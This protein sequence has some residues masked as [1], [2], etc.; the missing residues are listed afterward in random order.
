M[1]TTMYIA[2]HKKFHVPN[3]KGYKPIEVGADLRNGHFGYICDNDGE[4]ISKKN[5]TFCELTAFYWIWKNDKSD[6]VG[7]CHYRR[8]FSRRRINTSEKFYLKVDEIEKLLN[9]YDVI[10]PEPFYW[11]KHTVKTGYEFGAGF[12]RD[13]DVIEKIIEMQS[14][15]FVYE[16]R[17]IMQENKASYCNMFVMRKCMFDEYCKWL[18]DILFEAER[19]IDIS[20]YTQ[21]EKRIFGY[22]SEI[23]L[24]VWVRK[25]MKNIYYAPM[26][27]VTN[28]G[29][30]RKI[31]SMLDRCKVTRK[32]TETINCMDSMY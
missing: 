3:I 28:K 10:L 16:Y 7:L 29:K 13:L 18:F 21:S 31:L 22:I 9:N 26:C 1:K 5:T 12:V 30:K 2:S 15:E 11:R 23:L 4:N 6:N 27:L 8:Y 17:N 19:R 32:V 14:P 25:K 24:N 20:E